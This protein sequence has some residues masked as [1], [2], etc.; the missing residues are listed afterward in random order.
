M[1]ACHAAELGF[2]F[3]TLVASAPLNGPDAPQPLADAMHGAWVAFAGSGDPGW[4]RYGDA[5]NVRR[6]AEAVETVVDPRGATRELWA[7]LR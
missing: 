3:D 2:V 6:F 7:G 1:G 4:E 5:R